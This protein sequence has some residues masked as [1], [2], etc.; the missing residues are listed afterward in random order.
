MSEAI[1]ILVNKKSNVYNPF[2]AILVVDDDKSFCKMLCKSIESFIENCL[3][4]G[5][6]G[7]ETALGLCQN[8]YF[9][10]ILCDINMPNMYGDELISRVKKLSPSTYVVAMT[11]FG[12]EMGFRAGR[13]QAENFFDKKQ[14]IENLN[15][16]LK[17]GLAEASARRTRILKHDYSVPAAKNK[18]KKLHW[19]ERYKFKQHFG[20]TP[21]KYT[22]S[23]KRIYAL[24]VLR[25]R[26]DMT[27]NEIS[28]LC[29]FSSTQKMIRSV[30]PVLK[31]CGSLIEES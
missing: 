25:L 2:S 16:L 19:R 14:A 29:G 6:A 23:R 3:I 7:P 1:E 20:C 31:M 24:S 10:V 12:P 15:G 4:I 18:I 28:V 26:Q 27:K 5:C 13:S 21:Q 30:N 11:G 8:I 17:S 22:A 9:D